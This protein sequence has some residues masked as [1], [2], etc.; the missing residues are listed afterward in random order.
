MVT[1]LTAKHGFY[2]LPVA[3]RRVKRN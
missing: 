3:Y 1:F 2:L